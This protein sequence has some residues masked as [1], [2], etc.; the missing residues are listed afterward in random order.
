[1]YQVIPYAGHPSSA[2]FGS[3]FLKWSLALRLSLAIHLTIAAG[4]LNNQLRLYAPLIIVIRKNANKTAVKR[5][6]SN[7]ETRT[8]Q[9]VLHQCEKDSLN[10][11]GNVDRRDGYCSRNILCFL[12]CCRG[13]RGGIGCASARSSKALANGE[14]TV[15]ND[16]INALV[17][18]NLYVFWIVVQDTVGDADQPRLLYNPVNKEL[19]ISNWYIRTITLWAIKKGGQT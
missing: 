2:V 13:G 6:S 12:Y 18:L 14:D 11:R 5:K 8:I 7:K 1:M 16:S 3:W 9:L 10:N 4:C 19:Y 15:D 17:Y